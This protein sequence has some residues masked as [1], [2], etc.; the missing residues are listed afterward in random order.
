ME[1]AWQAI[2][3]VDCQEFWHGWLPDDGGVTMH[4]Q[5]IEAQQALRE[6]RG[7]SSPGQLFKTEVVGREV[8]GGG[9]LGFILRAARY[10]FPTAPPRAHKVEFYC[11]FALLAS[12]NAPPRVY[13]DSRGF[14]WP[15]RGPAERLWSWP[16]DPSMQRRVWLMNPFDL[17]ADLDWLYGNTVFVC[18]PNL[19][20]IRFHYRA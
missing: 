11:N 16:W 12:G 8:G 17:Y 19:L 3:D 1:T 14:R 7:V 20:L 13:V 2:T 9:W 4:K 15:I 18:Y 6:W 5:F 10:R